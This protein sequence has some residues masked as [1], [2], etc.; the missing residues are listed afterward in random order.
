MSDASGLP[1]C[2]SGSFIDSID[3]FDPAFFGIST[4]EAVYMDPQQ[5]LFLEEAWKALEDAGYA[6][7]GVHEM[8]CG[9]YVGC[10]GSNYDRLAQDEPPPQAFWG[11]S[12]AV[13]PARIAYYLNLR[14]PAIAVD[15]ACS[16]S[17]VTIHLACQSLWAGETSMAVAGGVFLQPTP[18]FY[19]VANRAGMLSPD[20]KCYSFD[21]RANGFVPGEGV[22]VVI[23]KRLR[24]A[25]R[26]GDHIHGVIAG[27][28]INQDG[29]SN[30]LIA[31]NGRAQEQLE[32]SVY[33]RFQ[34][35]PETIQVVEAHATGTLLG[36]SVEYGAL[37]R[38]F[39]G[40]TDKK[41]FCA[42][43][44]VKTNVGHAATAAG[45]AGVLKILL[46]LR[47]RRIPPSLHFESGNPAIDLE[48]GPFY[49]N[50]QMRDWQVG[51]GEVRRAAVSAFGFSGTNAHLVL[52]EAPPIERLATEAP[53]YLV[54]LSAR[55]AEQLQQQARNLLGWLR[56]T[57]VPMND[58]SFSLF[59]GRMHHT[60][61]LACV[62]RGQEELAHVL[63]QWTDGGAANGVYA[64][65]VSDRTREHV[66]L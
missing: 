3:R 45:V 1:Y 12:Q 59:V 16:S 7:K 47:H 39:R 4:E 15:T 20:G 64:S 41:H 31:P 54:V 25:V 18:G 9:V 14:G 57:A 66:A 21:A 28:G 44:T 58:L 65:E 42:L 35:N 13:L 36:D 61:R 22:G 48:S 33:D 10:G 23:L 40:F 60:H 49:V 17:L 11:N 46:A 24:D 26:D 38:T 8:D 43:G 53:A 51:E 37:S 6:G 55:T 62:V 19:Q 27:S 63:G 29:K 34:I 52:E 50:T 5:R 2:S 56:G 32:R 30:G